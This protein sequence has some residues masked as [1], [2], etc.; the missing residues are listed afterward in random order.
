MKLLDKLL[1]RKNPG[2]K[3]P[4]FVE[5]G[6]RGGIRSGEVRRAK[7]EAR[8]LME[9]GVSPTAAT[10]ASNGINESFSV[11]PTELAEKVAALLENPGE[12]DPMEPIEVM[13]PPNTMESASAEEMTEEGGALEDSI[14]SSLEP[15]LEETEAELSDIKQ[16]R[17]R[18]EAELTDIKRILPSP[19]LVEKAMEE[20]EHIKQ[21][22]F[23][24]PYTLS[25]LE[26]LSNR[27]AGKVRTSEVSEKGVEVSKEE[28]R[29]VA[30]EVK[31]ILRA[32]S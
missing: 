28:T 6:R 27:G 18:T 8:R 11:S 4:V 17:E 25:I 2:V 26:K 5:A 15:A 21:H 19:Q 9:E 23:E 13:A 32:A 20:L 12:P 3:N 14:L 16:I 10:D 30:E 7:A 31:R 1:K 29:S 22:V 24:I